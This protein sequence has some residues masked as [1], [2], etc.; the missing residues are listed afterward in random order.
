M[1]HLTLYIQ[2]HKLQ[3]YNECKL[4]QF[5]LF[6]IKI[7][8]NMLSHVP[9]LHL[10]MQLSVYVIFFFNLIFI[11]FLH[12]H[13]VPFTLTSNHHTV[14]PVHEC[15]FLFAHPSNLS[16][17]PHQLSSALHLSLTPFSLLVQFVCQIPHMSEIIQCLS[18]SH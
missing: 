11:L 13:L 9:Y 15:F 4:F 1:Q 5:Y 7:D 2:A 17:P 8:I 10:Y 6:F 16:C 18:F 12:Y 3:I 14:I